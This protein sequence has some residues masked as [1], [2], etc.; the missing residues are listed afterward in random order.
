MIKIQQVKC[1]E[2]GPF[3]LVQSGTG[4]VTGL[5]T[6]ARIQIGEYLDICDLTTSEVV[7]RARAYCT[8]NVGA[9][10]DSGNGPQSTLI[11]VVIAQRE[12]G[13]TQQHGGVKALFQQ[14][15]VTSDRYGLLNQQEYQNIEQANLDFY[16]T[17]RVAKTAMSQTYTGGS[18]QYDQQFDMEVPTSYSP[19]FQYAKPV[20]LDQEIDYNSVS[21][22]ADVRA[23]LST[24]DKRAAFFAKYP[25]TMMGTHYISME[26]ENRVPLL[27]AIANEEVVTIQDLNAVGNLIGA[28]GSPLINLLPGNIG[29]T[30]ASIG[31]C[32]LW[33][34][35]PILLTYTEAGQAET[36]HYDTVAKLTV[37]AAGQLSIVLV[38]GAQTQGA[39]AA[40]TDLSLV[41]YVA[42]DAEFQIDIQDIYVNMHQ[43]RFTPRQR[44]AQLASMRNV[45]IPYITTR[46]QP[47]NMAAAPFYSETFHV[48][49]NCV[50]IAALTPLD[51]S[52]ISSWDNATSYRWSINGVPTT[53]QA[54]GC[55]VII[56][57]QQLGV[58][59]QLHNLMLERFFEN[60]AMA[61]NN[62][63]L[64]RFDG[65]FD[66]AD[67]NL[68]AAQNSNHSM[69]PTIVPLM[70]GSAMITFR[71]DASADMEPKTV[72]FYSYHLNFLS[73][74]D[75]QL[76]SK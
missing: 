10:A 64:Q 76:V 33:V 37:T 6:R 30:Q 43:Y 24:L 69:F 23:P 49:P 26:L 4:V 68:G 34:G 28:A 25:F 45:T 67:A 50:G 72:Y 14:V 58:Q 39:A 27:S 17:G 36:T 52:L 3:S 66:N 57:D 7:V 29:Y 51:G 11:P 47:F 74:K 61:P 44:E 12:A 59:R 1:D 70:D 16:T 35:A 48:D 18:D 2:G 60:M 20:I 32:P 62:R 56:G 21:H 22:L 65:W 13:V 5:N 19:F 55:G 8:S 42:D 75:G 15:K 41:I 54:I 71:I 53:N 9:N 38:N 40:V 31:K 73:F 46:L 63:R